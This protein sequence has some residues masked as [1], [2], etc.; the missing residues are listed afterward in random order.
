MIATDTIVERFEVDQEDIHRRANFLYTSR[1]ALCF[2]QCRTNIILATNV[3]PTTTI[4][5]T[6]SGTTSKIVQANA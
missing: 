2:P 5:I 6:R 1:G 3:I 4:L